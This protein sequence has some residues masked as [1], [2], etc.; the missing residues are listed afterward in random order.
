M[1]GHRHASLEAVA[2]DCRHGV[3]VVSYLGGIDVRAG[4][5]S[6]LG[7]AASDAGA[8]DAVRASES[9]VHEFKWSI[10]SIGLRHGDGDTGHAAH[11]VDSSGLSPL[12]VTGD[13][14][15]CEGVCAGDSCSEVRA[16]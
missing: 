12:A 7:C 15:H 9:G 11:V 10:S 6:V 1:V 13:C 5:S 2:G 4:G 3:G 14:R 8:I 16:G